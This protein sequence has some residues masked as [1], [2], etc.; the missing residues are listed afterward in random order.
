MQSAYYTFK[1]HPNFRKIKFVILPK[2]REIISHSSGVP[3]NIDS[4]I[5][6]LKDLFPNL[7][8]SELDKYSDRL[9]YFIE[10][11]DLHMYD[12]LM[13]LKEFKEKD[14][15]QSNI[16]DLIIE[17][18][19]GTIRR[20]VE[21]NLN[22][23]RR[24]NATKKL[25]SEYTSTLAPTDKVVVVSHY[26]FLMMWT[27]EWHGSMT[28]ENGDVRHP[29]SSFHFHSSDICYSNTRISEFDGPAE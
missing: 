14:E 25:V 19:Q 24:V 13:E 22:V 2:T 7:D 17:R 20:K 29:D 12:E 28:N 26:F 9:H 27:G 23:L 15:I 8:D 3:G 6:E 11:L 18:S 21:S 1:E 16:F 4:T 5:S 10:D